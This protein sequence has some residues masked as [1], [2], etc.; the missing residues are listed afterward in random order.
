MVS[1]SGQT[2]LSL[3][4]VQRKRP[5]WF[6]V[7]TNNGDR[8]KVRGLKNNV[9]W[10][11]LGLEPGKSWLTRACALRPG[12]VLRD[13]VCLTG[14]HTLPFSPTHPYNRRE[15]RPHKEQDRQVKQAG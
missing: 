9:P 6:M 13:C 5:L 12:T 1:T 11:L 8:G 14:T 4:T 3:H 10:R 15:Q 2:V 7:S